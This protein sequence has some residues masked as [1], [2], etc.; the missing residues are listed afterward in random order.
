MVDNSCRKCCQPPWALKVGTV[1]GFLTTRKML[2]SDLSIVWNG[3]FGSEIHSGHGDPNT[4][5]I[6]GQAYDSNAS[7]LW[8]CATSRSADT[9][10]DNIREFDDSDG[11]LTGQ[12]IVFSNES[13]VGA[14]C[15][16]IAVDSSGNIFVVGEEFI[17]DD[18][19]QYVSGRYFNSSLTQQWRVSTATAGSNRDATCCAFDGSDVY[20]LGTDLIGTGDYAQKY[21]S[22]G[23]QQ[24]SVDY[25]G[26]GG[27]G[28]AASIF[29][30]LRHNGVS[31][32]YAT[33]QQANTVH[34]LSL[35]SFSNGATSVSITTSD[36]LVQAADTVPFSKFVLGFSR[37][38]I[39]HSI[40]V[41]DS[42]SNQ[43]ATFDTGGAIWDLVT[44]SSNIYAVGERVG[45]KS[46]WV[47]EWD[48]SAE[49]LTEVDS[50]DHGADL[51]SIIKQGSHIYVSGDRTSKQS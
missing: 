48:D 44:D 27:V 36:D 34:E 21:N 4:N 5:F 51:H 50:F 31:L 8:A 15:N 3:D 46:L 18:D 10:F 25:G 7:S 41:R 47:L 16:G 12:S 26:G 11:S 1:G 28:V 35:L 20:L 33:S 40:E 49:T 37:T 38:S 9:S 14:D 19:G 6:L 42:S 17:D 45:T 39:S 30:T 22:S 23:T 43:L 32:L 13:G 24:W 29:G 2:L